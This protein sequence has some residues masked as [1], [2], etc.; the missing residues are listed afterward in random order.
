MNYITLASKDVWQSCFAQTSCQIHFTMFCRK[1]T[2]VKFTQ[3]LLGK[4][5]FDVKKIVFFHV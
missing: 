2:F 5:V 3:F 4:I 1:F